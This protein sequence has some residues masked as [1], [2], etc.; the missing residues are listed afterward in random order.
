MLFLSILAG[1]W[2]SV[3]LTARR[4]LAAAVPSLTDDERS[5]PATPR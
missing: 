2:I 3:R 5:D 1:R 4:R